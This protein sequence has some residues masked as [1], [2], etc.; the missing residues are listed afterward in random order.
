MR[1]LTE[2]AHCGCLTEMASL[3]WPHWGSLTEA[4][5]LLLPHWDCITVAASLSS[6]LRLPHCG[7]LTVDTSLRLCY[8][9]CPL[10]LCYCECLTVDLYLN[11]HRSYV[12]CC[13]K[14]CAT[15]LYNFS[16]CYHYRKVSWQQFFGILWSSWTKQTQKLKRDS[17]QSN[18]RCLFISACFSCLWNKVYTSMLAWFLVTLKYL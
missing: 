7:I 17:S 4:G 16:L 8:C 13:L 15:Y 2:A 6:S 3:R 5:W 14:D 12:Q 9:D 11:L 1:L 18:Q 10:R